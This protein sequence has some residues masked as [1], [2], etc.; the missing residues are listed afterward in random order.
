M[1]RVVVAL[2]ILLPILT[3]G[4]APAWGADRK[5]VRDALNIGGDRL[6]AMQNPDGGWFVAAGDTDCGPGGQGSCPNTLGVTALGLVDSYWV[7]RDRSHLAAAKKAADA[8]V[9]A[10]AASPACDGNPA[11][12]A[13]RPFTVDV[14]FLLEGFGKAQGK[15]G[16]I[17]RNTARAWFQCVMDDFPEASDRADERIDT[18]IGQGLRNLGAWDASLDVRAALAVGAP[19]YA[20]QEARRII[21]RASDWDVAVQKCQDCELLGKGLFLAATRPLTIYRD[22]QAARVR[23]ANELLAA[24]SQPDGSWG[25]DTQTTAYVTMG[26]ITMGSHKGA[27]AAADAAIAFLLSMQDPGT[28]GFIIGLGLTSERTEVD[29]EALQT[30]RTLWDDN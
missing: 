24:Q 26:L 10:H 17:Y 1:Q 15:G 18:R 14:S 22:V 8:V 7:T 16:A 5:L 21:A 9:A 23:F 3:A 28:G 4:F 30:L 19:A 13:D 12:S 25:G 20:L 29:A 27:R 2:S 11:T 6:V